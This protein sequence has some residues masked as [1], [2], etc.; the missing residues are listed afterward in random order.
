MG[1]QCL[2]TAFI[3]VEWY[4]VIKMPKSRL[5]IEGLQLSDIDSLQATKTRLSI[6][7]VNGVK[8]P[9][10]VQEVVS[11]S[12]RQT[13]SLQ[14]DKLDYDTCIKWVVS[15]RSSWAR[16]YWATDQNYYATSVLP[17]SNGYLFGGYNNPE[18]G[19]SSKFV[20]KTDNLGN[21]TKA[22]NIGIHGTQNQI[23]MIRDNSSYIVVGSNGDIFVAK[24]NS[25]LDVLLFNSYGLQNTLYGY[26]PVFDDSVGAYVIPGQVLSYEG[27]NRSGLVLSVSTDG[28]VNF[29][30]IYVAGTYSSLYEVEQLDGGYIVVG[31]YYDTQS[32]LSK[33]LVIWTDC[34]GNMVCARTFDI[35]HSG[36]M[37][38]CGIIKNSSGNY[39]LY[40]GKAVIEIDGS[41]NV[42]WAGS[43][44]SAASVV[45][46]SVCESADGYVL[47]GG[48]GT[49]P[50]TQVAI[51][52]DKS[53]GLI[54]AKTYD[55]CSEIVGWA[56][57]VIC[58]TSGYVV[59]GCE[60]IGATLFKLDN[61]MNISSDDVEVTDV[62]SNISTSDIQVTVDDITSTVTVDDVT[63]SIQVQ[64][65]LGQIDISDIT[66]EIQT[67]RNCIGGGP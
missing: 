2:Y 46:H 41:G 50:G 65:L 25:N 36:L 27:T 60:N 23:S 58:M 1:M 34:S 4:K 54:S 61:N 22:L 14:T 10:F 11:P 18:Y 56:S 9:S 5:K 57:D 62:T 31:E 19:T 49:E 33:F 42:M 7:I 26:K 20:I 51:K 47:V 59:A 6:G 43:Y 52:T 44:D 55:M 38:Y 12:I 15:Y 64:D 28:S 8:V 66:S 35:G 13:S 21:V 53:G 45:I 3:V 39:L 37:T 67:T 30:K 24:L 17:V 63:D 40:S 32:G 29:A 48:Y 16:M